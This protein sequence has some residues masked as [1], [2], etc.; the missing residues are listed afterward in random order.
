MTAATQTVS[1]SLEQQQDYAFLVR[2]DGTTIANLMTDEPAPLGAGAGPNPTRMLAVAVAN[3]LSAS[4]LFAMRK[5]KNQ[6]GPLK[7]HATATLQANDHGRLRVAHIQVDINLAEPAQSHQTL[8]R[9]LGQ[10]ENFCVVTESVRQ[11]VD[12]SVSIRDSQGTLLHGS[13]G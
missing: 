13:S 9:L 10:F 1:I 12:V 3:C 2:F 4:L 11:G 8:E 6:P 5:Y 7:T